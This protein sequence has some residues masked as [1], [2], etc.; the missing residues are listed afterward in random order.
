MP[1]V[2]GLIVP[3]VA[4]M[5]HRVMALMPV[6][7]MMAWMPVV[8]VRVHCQDWSTTAGNHGRH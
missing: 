7:I 5:G 8:D 1:V 3:V 6:V 4:S 2:A